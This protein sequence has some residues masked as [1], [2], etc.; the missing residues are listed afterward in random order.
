LLLDS[1]LWQCLR[2]RPL[3]PATQIEIERGVELRVRLIRQTRGHAWTPNSRE[4]RSA[5]NPVSAMHVRIPA[6]RFAQK[7]SSI[8]LD[9]HILG[10]QARGKVSPFEARLP[11]RSP[12]AVSLMPSSASSAK[13]SGRRRLVSLHS[14]G[15]KRSVRL[16]GLPAQDLS[17]FRPLQSS[18]TRL[19][20]VE[21]S[22]FSKEEDTSHVRRK[23]IC[24]PSFI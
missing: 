20:Q 12:S 13:R 2:V 11:L 24:H 17:G 4:Y 6:A 15:A 10:E 1:G 19:M 22:H 3:E 7:N 14:R 5:S 8:L 9:T 21:T 18:P 23:Q 16:T